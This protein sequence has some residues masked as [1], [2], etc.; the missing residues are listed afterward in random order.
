M[1]NVKRPS[2]DGGPEDRSAVKKTKSDQHDYRRGLPPDLLRPPTP[3]MASRPVPPPAPSA[4]SGTG[5]QTA[6]K[7]SLN[8][9]GKQTG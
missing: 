6:S 7:I 8:L 4:T 9:K 2:T 5:T 1:M 3:P